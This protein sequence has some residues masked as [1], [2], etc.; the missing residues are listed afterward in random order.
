MGRSRI[1]P[2]G[3]TDA[4]EG[5]SVAGWKQPLDAETDRP[6]VPYGW[7]SALVAGR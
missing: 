6:Q 7:T 1:A 4:C 3:Y 2:I 5:I